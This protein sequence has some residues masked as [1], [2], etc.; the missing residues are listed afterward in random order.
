[1]LV[2]IVEPDGARA[3]RWASHIE[4]LGARTARAATRAAAIA[5]LREH[6]VALVVLDLGLA[7]DGAFAVADFASYAR[8]DARVLFVSS[9]DMLTDGSV[10]RYASNACGFVGVDSPPADIAALAVHHAGR[11]RGGDA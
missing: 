10:F 3:A 1:M 8:P 4:A 11:V 9:S 7:G 6:D 2:L 5:A